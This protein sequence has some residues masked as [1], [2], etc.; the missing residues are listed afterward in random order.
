MK[1]KSIFFLLFILI[2]SSCNTNKTYSSLSSSSECSHFS[3]NDITFFSWEL[4]NIIDGKIENAQYYLDDELI[5]PTYKLGKY[6]YQINNENL[7][8]T[9]RIEHDKYETKEI[10]LNKDVKLGHISLEYTFKEFAKSRYNSSILNSN[11]TGY[12][13][14]GLE[15]LRLKFQSDKAQFINTDNEL[16]VF[17]NTGNTGSHLSSGD[18]LFKLVA[19]DFFVYDYG[20]VHDFTDKSTFHFNIDTKNETILYLDIPYTYLQIDPKDV[21]GINYYEHITSKDIIVPM[22]FD[23]QIINSQNTQNYERIN[24]QGD[25]FANSINAENPTW[26]SKSKKRELIDGKDYSF[27]SPVYNAHEEADDI[28]FSIEYTC[29]HLSFDFVGFGTFQNEEYFK[30]VIHNNIIDK[31]AWNLTDDDVIIHIYNNKIDIFYSITYFFMIEQNNIKPDLT[32]P[33]DTFIDNVNHFTLK[34]SIPIEKITNIHSEYDDIY[35]MIVEFGKNGVFYQGKNYN[36][37]FFYKGVTV[38]DPADMISYKCIDAPKKR[39]CSL[40]DNQKLNLID[41]R[42]ISFA[43]PIET[44]FDKADDF[45]MNINRNEEGLEL[46]II[47]FGD[48]SPTEIITIVFHSSNIDGTDWTIQTDDKSLMISQNKAKW[49]TNTT[50]YWVATRLSRGQEDTIHP[51]KYQRFDDYFTLQILIDYLEI[52]NGIALSSKIRIYALEFGFG[53]VLYNSAPWTKA[54]KKNGIDCGDPAFQKNYISI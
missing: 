16:Y 43:N 14:R 34:V 17:I 38:G 4:E 40:S 36:E 24:V 46:D 50:D 41:N 32:L 5:H 11:F 53:G 45:Y 54:M 28:Y 3:E 51:I 20:F 12:S 31:N 10:V 1:S 29:T 52:G 33:I 35:I 30:L 44:K 7:P 18:Y 26:I 47:G 39:T 25:F 27:A 9:L 37:N 23:E 48:F 8:A 49:V 13:T 15:Y 21:I 19:T 22:Q 2:F 6:S 42:E